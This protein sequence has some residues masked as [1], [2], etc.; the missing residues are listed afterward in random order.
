MHN[1]KI[2]KWKDEDY[3]IKVETRDKKGRFIILAAINID[4]IEDSC[5]DDYTLSWGMTVTDMFGIVLS[6]VCVNFQVSDNLIEDCKLNALPPKEGWE[7]VNSFLFDLEKKYPFQNYQIIFLSDNQSYDVAHTDYN[8][9]KYCNKRNAMR[10]FSTN[11]YIS[12][13][14]ADNMLEMTHKSFEK[15]ASNRIIDVVKHDHN[16]VNDAHFICLQYIEALDFKAIL[17]LLFD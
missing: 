10:Y 11:Q 3:E 14:A 17:N 1:T 5:S 8:L 6:Q 13:K 12:V 15:E 4:K 16:P 7:K 2:V 9:N